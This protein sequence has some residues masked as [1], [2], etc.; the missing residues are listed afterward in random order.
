M[1]LNSLGDATFF[2]G[3]KL[4]L[5]RHQFQCTE[6]DD[7]WRAWEG[8]HD[9][10]YLTW[11]A[12]G[13]AHG[14]IEL[15]EWTKQNWERVEKEVPVDIASTFLGPALEGLHTKDQI[16]EVRGFFARCDTKSYQMVLYQN[17]E[18]MENRRWWAERDLSNVCSWLEAHGYL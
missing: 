5:R 3:L 2:D 9:M 13:T 6:S 1:I 4:Y 11:L 12:G 18:G 17:L 10:F 16:E 14:A 15:W 7:L 8:N